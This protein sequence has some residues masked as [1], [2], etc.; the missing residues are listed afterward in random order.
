[1]SSF[2]AFKEEAKTEPGKVTYAFEGG[3]IEVKM[4]EDAAGKIFITLK[5]LDKMTTVDFISLTK[6]RNA[7]VLNLKMNVEDKTICA[8]W[9]NV[10]PISI[11][12]DPIKV[13]KTTLEGK[14]LYQ[15]DNIT[16]FKNL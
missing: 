6:N 7:K 5:S 16:I 10:K 15:K 13:E 1:M 3:K 11:E 2:A 14:V 12:L 9:L 4:E 8:G